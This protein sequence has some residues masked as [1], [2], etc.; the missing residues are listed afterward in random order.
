MMKK[1]LL[2]TVTILSTLH[3]FSQTEKG[4]IIISLDGNY[5]QSTTENGV[6]HNQNMTEGKYLDIGTSIGY[7]I[8]SR[9]IAGIGLDYNWDK[10]VREN[11]LMINSYYQAEVTNVKSHVFLPNMYLGY[12]YPITTNLYINASLKFS[13]GKIKSEYDTF[14]AGSAYNPSNT[15][16]ELTDDYSASGQEGTSKVDF[17]SVDIIPELTYFFSSRFSIYVGLGGVSYS[18]LEWDTDNSSWNVN[19]NPSY[20]KTGIKIRI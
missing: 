9:L 18:L 12:Y 13:Y 6:T 15:S 5:R 3:L 2:L 7:F 19:F 20:W 11:S 17:F 1:L 8:N 4:E 16:I 14:W 10:E